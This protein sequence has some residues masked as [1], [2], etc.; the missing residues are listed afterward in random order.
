MRITDSVHALKIPF[1]VTTQLGVKV[2]RFVY[3]YIIFG[4]RI[5]LVDSGVANSE[6]AIF[7]YIRETGRNPEEISLLILTHSH[8]DHIGAARAIKIVTGCTICAHPAEKMWI[9]DVELQSKERP[10]PGFNDLVGGSVTVD[11]VLEEGNILKIDENLMIEVFHTPGHSKGSISLR[12]QPE[13]ILF[14]GD[15]IPVPG[16]IPIYED[17][18]S[19][20]RSI[21]VLM[22]LNGIRLLLSSWDD[23]QEGENIA[24]RF[25]A[26]IGF[27]QRIHD[28]VARVADLGLAPMEMCLRVLNAMGLSLAIANPLLATTFISHLKV[29]PNGELFRD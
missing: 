11:C 9:E 23:P 15:A 6:H 26:S 16:D 13:G 12:L 29:R 21:R 4:K 27:L 28:A 7:K 19:L 2:K 8:P 25:R 10:V 17:I 20:V 22:G 14:T 24:Q 3:V 5:F 18:E 1:H